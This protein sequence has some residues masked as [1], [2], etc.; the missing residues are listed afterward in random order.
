MSVALNNNESSVSVPDSSL[1]TRH[2]SL[3]P[4]WLFSRNTDLTVFLGSAVVS[5]LAL[6]VGARS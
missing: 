1:V 3:A 5:L 6:W 4:V 2:S